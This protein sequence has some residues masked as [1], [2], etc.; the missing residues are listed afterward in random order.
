MNSDERHF[1]VRLI[2]AAPTGNGVGL[3]LVLIALD[4][5]LLT[6]SQ[7]MGMHCTHMYT[8]PHTYTTH[9]TTHI[10][11]TLH[12]HTTPH[13]THHTTHIH[14]PLHTPHTPH[15]PYTHHSPHSPHIPQN[16]T[17]LRVDISSGHHWLLYN[18][19]ENGH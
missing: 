12:T 19:V 9:Y 13:Y 1:P 7:S 8:T 18:A 10:H 16:T 15:T 2:A 11:T 5:T 17:Y 4:S 14:T 6:R 3:G